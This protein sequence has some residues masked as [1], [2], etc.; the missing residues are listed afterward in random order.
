MQASR[1]RILNDPHRTL[2]SVHLNELGIRAPHGKFVGV[3]VDKLM[4]FERFLDQNP[5]LNTFSQY[6]KVAKNFG[7]RTVIHDVI[8]TD[9]LLS[10][11]RTFRDRSM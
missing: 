5:Q 2:R 1:D 11:M 6:Y 3:H 9:E 10:N 7:V 8:I 4:I